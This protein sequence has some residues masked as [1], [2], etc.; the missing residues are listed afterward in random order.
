MS[1][2]QPFLPDENIL[3]EQAGW[4]IK[5]FLNVKTGTIILTNKR[6]AFIEQKQVVGGGIVV[7]AADAISSTSRPKHKLDVPIENIVKWEQPRKIDIRIE[8][9]N[10]Q[11]H[12]LRGVDYSVWD[13]KLKELKKI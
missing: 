9:A 10:G 11:K 3:L 13:Q 4:F 12:T 5:G 2:F 6:L 8:E 7:A 1:K